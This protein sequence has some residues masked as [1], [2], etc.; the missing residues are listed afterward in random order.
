MKEFNILVEMYITMV[1]S[2]DDDVRQN[3]FYE[4]CR[5]RGVEPTEVIKEANRVLEER[6]ELAERYLK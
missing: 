5:Q 4:A 6:A 2:P 3:W 1:T